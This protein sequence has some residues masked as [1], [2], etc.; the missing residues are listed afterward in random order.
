MDNNGGAGDDIKSYS[1]KA[2]TAFNK[3]AEM[4]R[5]S[6][7][8]KNTA[9]LLHG[10]KTRRIAKRDEVKSNT[11][12]HKDLWRVLKILLADGGYH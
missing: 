9:V 12:L 1:G 5:S 3:L 10:C 7:L 6:Q 11:F 2:T 4:W 8:S